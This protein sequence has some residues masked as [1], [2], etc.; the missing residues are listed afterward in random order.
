M[1]KSSRLGGT[2]LRAQYPIQRG[3]LHATTTPTPRPITV[4]FNTNPAGLSYR[5]DGTTYNSAHV[6]SWPSGSSHTI[7]TT[8]PQSR[9]SG[10]RY[11]W[12]S[13]SDNGAMSHTIAPTTSTA[14]T[15]TFTT[16]YHL[17]MNART[18]GTV[19]PAS[20]WRNNG[21]QVTI[22]AT[23]S[24]GYHF[25]GWTGSGNGSYSGT[26]NPASVTMNGPITETASF[27]Q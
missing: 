9:G 8:S 23:P 27:S 25:A 22:R 20:G 10:V 12:Q 4:T 3:T 13:W 15:A 19:M 16:Q 2:R 18:G 26:N 7:S 24:N 21:A 1:D 11:V 14:Y 5:V 17:T 6:F